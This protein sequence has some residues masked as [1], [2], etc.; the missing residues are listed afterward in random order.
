MAEIAYNQVMTTG[1][2]K[3]PPTQ[4]NA[5]QSKVFVNGQALLVAGDLANNHGHDPVGMCVASQ[6]K[7]FVNG[8]AVI[9]KGDSL[10]DG[11]KIAQGAPNVF[12]N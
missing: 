12:I 11:D 6:S 10:T 8:I 2:G 3:Y 9:M 1:H 7:V 5:S 4:V